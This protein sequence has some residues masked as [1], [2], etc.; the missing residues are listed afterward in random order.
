MFLGSKP[1]GRTKWVGSV[2]W[3]HAGLQNHVTGVRFPPDSPLNRLK[4]K[5]LLDLPGEIFL[6]GSRTKGIPLK[7]CNDYDYAAQDTPEMRKAI[8][9]AGFVPVL[10]NDYGGVNLT[11]RVFNKGEI[12][13]VLK[14]DL[15]LFKKVWRSISPY[16]FETYIWRGAE[17]YKTAEN[18]EIEVARSAIITQIFTSVIAAIEK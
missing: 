16:F 18:A 5:E 10:P 13:I 9:K 17:M 1:S 4:M 3:K 8:E 7:L 14:S 6:F 15:E 12:D 11:T 2:K